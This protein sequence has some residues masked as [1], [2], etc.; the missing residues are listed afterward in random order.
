VDHDIA[1][2]NL[3][4]CFALQIGAKLAGSVH[5]RIGGQ[6]GAMLL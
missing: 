6:R 1:L 2:A 4:S 5:G 3:S